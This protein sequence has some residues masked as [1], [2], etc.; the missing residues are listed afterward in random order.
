[1]PD[2]TSAIQAEGSLNLQG[3]AN[4]VSSSKQASDEKG[5]QNAGL[6]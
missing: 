6:S 4:A 2:D 3:K 1:M 5:L